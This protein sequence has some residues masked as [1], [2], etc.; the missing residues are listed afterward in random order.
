MQPLRKSFSG[1]V[2]SVAVGNE[3]K[4]EIWSDCWSRFNADLSYPVLFMHLKTLQEGRQS[5]FQIR[6]AEG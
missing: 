5:Q 2:D 1:C 4:P 6:C 3:S